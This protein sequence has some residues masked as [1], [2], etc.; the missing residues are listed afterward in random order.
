[1]TAA[2]GNGACATPTLWAAQLRFEDIPAPV[3]SRVQGLL[4]DTLGVA[5]AA[6]R[7]PAASIA[8]RIAAGHF[9]V[10]R[11]QDAVRLPFDG[12]ATSMPGAAY[13]LAT[14]IDSLHAHDGYQ[15]A[16]GHAGV[17]LVAGLLA[18]AQRRPRLS[19]REALAALVVGYEVACRAGVALRDTASDYHSSGAWNALGV[20]ALGCRLGPEVTAPM[21]ERALGIAEYHAPRA[22]MMREIDHPSML[23]D[24]SGWGALAG[25]SAVLLAAEGFAASPAELPRRESAAAPWGGLGQRWLVMEQYVKPHPV[26]FWA[27]PAVRAALYLRTACGVRPE[28]I[29]RIRIETFHEASRLAP[30]TP[31]TTEAA[32]YALAFPVACALRFGAVGPEEI[33][34][35]GLRD[36]TVSALARTVE[37]HERADLSARFPDERVA[38]VAITL[39]DGAVVRSGTFQPRGTPADPLDGTAIEDKF[40][41]Y[42]DGLIE[43]AHQDELMAA[44]MALHEPGQSFARVLGHCLE[45]SNADDVA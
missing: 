15:P 8:Y 16:R 25:T 39:D 45:S 28:D 19:G 44:V 34:G 26:C 23:H 13:A 9:G 31:A 36:E 42:T 18:I 41:Q 38:E 6:A 3:V 33:A 2:D 30:G 4:L 17:A 10:A 22:P 7:V 32:Q 43:P 21:I 11:E 27:Q 14:R 5:V 12:R 1:M 40:R 24:S 20:A 29:A 37:V 35:S